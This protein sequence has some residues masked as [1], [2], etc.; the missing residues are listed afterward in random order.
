MM[1]LVFRRP[2]WKLVLIVLDKRKLVEHTLEWC[3]DAEDA[4]LLFLGPGG[5]RRAAGVLRH[6][7]ARWGVIFGHRCTCAWH[8]TIVTNNALGGLCRAGGECPNAVRLM[9]STLSFNL[10][11][12]SIT[13]FSPR[14]CF[15]L[16][17]DGILR[18]VL[19]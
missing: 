11:P 19:Y 15:E 13:N 16:C 10:N 8:F 3:R 7:G 12:K 5:R 6:G 18:A 17:P 4:A 1:A 14:T 2:Q 9:S